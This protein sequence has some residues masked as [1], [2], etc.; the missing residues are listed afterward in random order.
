VSALARSLARRVVA[1]ALVW[2]LLP[3]SASRAEGPNPFACPGVADALIG[4]LST[5]DMQE[6]RD[7]RLT[8]PPSPWET[9]PELAQRMC[10]TAKIMARLGDARASEYFEKAI[11]ANPAEGGYELWYGDYLGRN[12]G[13]RYPLVEDSERHLYRALAKVRARRA[14]G[15]EASFDHITEEWAQRHLIDLY[16]ADGLP[17]LPWK[18]Y[19]YSSTSEQAPGVFLTAQNQISVDTTDFLDVADVRNFTS[20]MLFAESAERLDRQLTLAEK[21]ALAHAPLRDS[22]LARLRLR[23]NILGAID[24]GYR[25]LYIFNGQVISYDQ[26]TVFGNAEVQDFG[27]TYKRGFNLY[28]VF[29]AT[30]EASYHEIQRQG[31]VEFFPNQWENIGLA[32]V[33]PSVSRFIGPDVLTVGATYVNMNISPVVGGE[34]DQRARARAIT[35]AYFD[36]AFYRPLLLPQTSESLRVR[37]QST[38][39][40]HL[41]GGAAFDNEV[42]GTRLAQ[43]RDYYGGTSLMG[44][45]RW[46]F[47]LQETLYQGGVTD[48]IPYNLTALSN[49]QLRT[50]F[51]PLYRII[52]GDA[53]PGMPPGDQPVFMNLVFP[54][55]T[56]YAIQG[57]NDFNNVRAGA[58]LWTRILFPHLR[59]T[60]FLISGGYSFQYFYNI[61]KPL[62]LARLDVGIGW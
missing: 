47:T 42:F 43:K 15:Q 39:G 21:Q 46:D 26:P 8:A 6:E 4:G 30:I 53:M 49:A 56:D 45:G 36:Y 1:G 14:A 12:R 20:Q 62:N 33:K 37:R 48:S 5:S 25:A 40:F 11:A 7:K 57:P 9:A 24:V 52:D 59:G 17:S 54:L 34:I 16:Q 18:G 50:S 38:R 41:F 27:V 60:S 31:I 61:Q 58:E 19:P 22:Y 10:V 55:R 44:L 29:D 3:A 23:Q 51:L 35:A 13:S 28:P 32:E 2:A